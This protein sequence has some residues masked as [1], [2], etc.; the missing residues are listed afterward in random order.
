MGP[1]EYSRSH[2][3]H[4]LRIPLLPVVN[5]NARELFPRRIGRMRGQG[6]SLAV[7]RELNGAGRSRLAAF[8]VIDLVMAIIDLLDGASVGGG[9]AGDGVI[10]AV[11]FSGPLVVSR[12]TSGIDAVDDTLVA[13]ARRRVHD[14]SV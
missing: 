8:F 11:K 9:I 12:L 6:A 2:A 5:R 14:V 1:T 13:V 10:F 3:F 7:G 4:C